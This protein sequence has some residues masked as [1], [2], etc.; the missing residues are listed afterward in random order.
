[1]MIFIDIFGFQVG[2]V[3]LAHFFKSTL[4]YRVGFQRLLA[5]DG[6]HHHPRWMGRGTQVFSPQYRQTILERV[7]VTPSGNEDFVSSRHPL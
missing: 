5:I 2:C 6:P 4:E 7:F 3:L 1:M